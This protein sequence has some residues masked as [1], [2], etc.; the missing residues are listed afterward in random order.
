MASLHPKGAEE[1]VE[2]EEEEDED[3]EDPRIGK[4]R[5]YA[6]KNTVKAT[7]ELLTSKIG[8]GDFKPCVIGGSMCFSSNNVMAYL[9][10]E[11]VLSIEAGK[12]SAQLKGS[13]GEYFKELCGGNAER[14][15][16]VLVALERYLVESEDLKDMR[17]TLNQLYA[18]EIVTS[19]DNFVRSTLSLSLSQLYIV[20]HRNR[21]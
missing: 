16:S 7:I 9:L 11:A 18:A 5:S 15:I 21:P 6:A 12:L 14:E 17:A 4:L 10:S 8:G 19:D 2:E 20:S 1:E 13:A 3:E